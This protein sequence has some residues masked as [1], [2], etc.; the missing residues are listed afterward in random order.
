M[1][2]GHNDNVY[3][4]TLS[5]E[6]PEAAL[7]KKYKMTYYE[8]AGKQP[9]IELYDI[10]TGKLFLKRVTYNLPEEEL[11]LGNQITVFA[12]QMT[13][14]AFADAKTA[15]RFAS[16]NLL[17]VVP[18]EPKLVAYLLKEVAENQLQSKL[19]DVRM[20]SFSRS[21]ARR[22][23][24]LGADPRTARILEAEAVL[25]INIRASGK[26][27]SQETFE[28]TMQQL[29]GNVWIPAFENHTQALAQIFS[30]NAVD[31]AKRTTARRQDCSVCVIKAHAVAAGHVPEIVQEIFAAGLVV[32]AV[33]SI[34]LTRVEAQEFLEVY[35]GVV[36]NFP[37]LVDELCR[38]R[39]VAIE[40]CGEDVVRRLREVAGPI[41]FSIAQQ[42]RPG[43]LRA[44][45]GTDSVKNAVHVTD[46]E[47]DGVLE[48]EYLF[49][50]LD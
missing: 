26:Q 46:L 32:T 22:M 7:V 44:R 4:F 5:W 10:K 8:R 37:A 34:S 42:I 2:Y 6:Q 29:Q 1:S 12:R 43:T 41:D 11:F 14:E 50:I 38:S 35:K 18:F 16:A 19:E 33:K 31:S 27:I 15:S 17:V 28:G 30:N 3:A 13:V 9:D 23:A 20:L 49:E 48:S 40:V 45:F 25:A 36:P 39:V 21:D 47:E 24:G